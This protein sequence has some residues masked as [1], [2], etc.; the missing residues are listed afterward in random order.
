MRH[1]YVSVPASVGLDDSQAAAGLDLP[2]IHARPIA[3]RNEQRRRVRAKSGLGPRRTDAT[4][5]S[6]EAPNRDVNE[7]RQAHHKPTAHKKGIPPIDNH[8][9][10]T[11]R[12]T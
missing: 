9:P 1:F 3:S 12:L 10:L 7:S 2:L 6:A 5:A 4:D 8:R 11:T